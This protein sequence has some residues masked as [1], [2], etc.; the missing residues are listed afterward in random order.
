MSQRIEYVTKPTISFCNELDLA[1]ERDIPDAKDRDVLVLEYDELVV[2][3]IGNAEGAKVFALD[4]ID[5]IDRHV[6]FDTG[7]ARRVGGD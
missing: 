7:R 1:E 5:A 2:I 6:D 3:P 4:I